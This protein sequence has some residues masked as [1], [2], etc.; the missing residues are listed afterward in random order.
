M[1]AT[2]ARAMLVAAAVCLLVIAFGFTEASTARTG[3]GIWPWWF[4][5]AASSCVVLAAALWSRPALLVS[6]ML[7]PLAFAAKAAGLVVDLV[8][9]LAP[10]RGRAI[11]GVALYA[12]VGLMAATTWV[13]VL[14]PVNSWVAQHRRRR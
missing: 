3:D 8:D 2:Q 5:A 1:R 10:D 11:A 9:E 4:A 13:F 6:G 12:L 7:V 14:A